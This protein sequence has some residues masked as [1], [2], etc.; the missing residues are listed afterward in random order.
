MHLDIKKAVQA[1]VQTIVVTGIMGFLSLTGASFIRG[2]DNSDSISVLKDTVSYLKR[3][4]VQCK[5]K[6]NQ[7]EK[8]LLINTERD[9]A[10]RENH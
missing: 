6:L 9:K 1:A 2:L 5:N 8:D 3:E 10:S 7:L 4:C